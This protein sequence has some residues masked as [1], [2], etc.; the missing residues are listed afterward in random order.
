MG[1]TAQ[2]RFGSGVE[3]LGSGLKAISGV[4]TSDSSSRRRKGS[5]LCKVRMVFLSAAS[6][7][8]VCLGPVR[9]SGSFE[10]LKEPQVGGFRVKRQLWLHTACT[11]T[12][13]V[14]KCNPPFVSTP[15]LLRWRFVLANYL[16]CTEDT[17]CWT[18]YETL[19]LWKLKTFKLSDVDIQ[20]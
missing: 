3:R 18:I 1:E 19:V 11:R 16:L 8:L 5:F 12:I 9:S 6:L 4:W 20:W 14:L 2:E 10:S 15:L 7:V 13:K 17:E